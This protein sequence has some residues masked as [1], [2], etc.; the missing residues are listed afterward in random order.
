[1]SCVEDLKE[2]FNAYENAM[3]TCLPKVDPKFIT[4]ILQLLKKEKAPMY[5]IEIFLNTNANIDEMRERVAEETG[6]VAT[7]H[8]R[9]TH[10]VVAHRITLE[11]LAEISSHEDVDEIK[12]THITRGTASIGPVF[13]RTKDEE[14]WEGQR[15]AYK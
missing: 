1:M 2:K 14:Y 9:G 3:K 15:D 12:G 7:F 5:T 4:E 11:Q 10:M 8:D 13:E 6:E